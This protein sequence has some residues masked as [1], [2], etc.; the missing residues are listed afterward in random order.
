MVEEQPLINSMGVALANND[1][2]KLF[3]KGR[4]L[5]L[6]ATRDY[7]TVHA[8]RQGQ[9]GELIKIPIIEGENELADRNRHIDDLHIE[10]SNIRRD[11]PAGTEVEVTL[12]MDESRIITVTAYV[13]MLDEEFSKKIELRKRN[14]EPEFLQADFDAEMKRFQA[15]KEKASA[16]DADSA[17]E[18]VGAVESSPLL[19]EVK[20]ALIAA[21]GDADAAAKC[22]KRILELKLKLDEATNALEW[23]ALVADA[24][25][26]AQFL[27]RVAEK[28]GTQQ[29]V[30][31]GEE[32]KAQIEEA[33]RTRQTDR[34][35]KRIEQSVGLYFEIV[36]AQ[37]GWW[38]HQFQE[39]EKQREKMS[40]HERGS[41]L[42]DQ[43]R[44]CMSRNNSA[45]LQT[46]VRQLWDLLPNEVTEA[47][48]RGYQSGIVR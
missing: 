10:A 42:L 48:K 32:L 3:E 23:P 37:A 40:D 24:N 41:R 25:E 38:V 15:A 33:I 31:R 34:L 21:R 27:K 8:I 19:N 36:M 4:G 35:R 11:L 45:G 6:K 26:T 18:L 20:E 7:R 22:E 9:T 1:Y 46:V 2:D 13:P 28:H 43:G 12:R 47:A 5:P 44:D 39:A 30:Q 17:E 14:P 29:Q 16:T